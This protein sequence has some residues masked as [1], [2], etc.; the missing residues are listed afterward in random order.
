MMGS[1]KSTVGQILARRLNYRFFD[2]D[3]LIEKVTGETIPAIFD[4]SGEEGFREIETKI[5]QELSAYT[6]SV[7]ATGGGIVLQ[8]VN[9]S[10]LRHDLIVWL[11]APIGVLVKR[12]ENDT[13]RPLLRDTELENRL[14]LLLQERRSLY[15]EADLRIAVTA[16][17]TPETVVDRILGAIPSVLQSS[18]ES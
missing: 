18:P 13:S 17:D 5:L 4:R 14:T 12:L 3:V 7:I 6:K 16:D 1:G 2:T 9:W 15:E 8:P 11:D 10:Y